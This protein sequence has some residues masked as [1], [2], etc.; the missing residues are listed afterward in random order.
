MYPYLFDW[1]INGHRL[2]IPSFGFFLALATSSAYFLSLRNSVYFSIGHT[3]IEKLFLITLGTSALGARLF[4]VIFEEPTF[5]FSH[6]EKIFAVWEGG[7]TLYGGILMA[8]AGIYLYCW[9]KKISFWSV[10]DIA[11]LSTALG[12]GIGR[13]GCFAAGCCWGKVCDLPWAITYTS[14]EA[15]NTIHNIPVHPVQL[16]ESLGAFTCLVLMQ[17]KVPQA[18]FPGQIGLTSIIFYGVLRFIVEYFRGDTYRGFIIEPWL[19]YSQ[20]ISLVMIL[21]ALSGL[22][23]L[24]RHPQSSR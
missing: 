3:H 6:P 15:F 20:L 8:L 22:A 7:Y 16:Y 12:I 13:L 5:Y 11:S 9:R 17:R 23:A 24:S 10:L 2:R 14:P 4:H 19:S 18:T 21:A 1:V